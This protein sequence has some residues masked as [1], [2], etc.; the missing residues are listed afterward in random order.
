MVPE[1]TLNNMRVRRLTEMKNIN[2]ELEKLGAPTYDQVAL[3][4]KLVEA[5]HG[6][7]KD[8]VKGASRRKRS[9][10]VGSTSSSKRRRKSGEKYRDSALPRDVVIKS[11]PSPHHHAIGPSIAQGA[12][13]NSYS[14]AMGPGMNVDNQAAPAGF[15]AGFGAMENLYNNAMSPEMSINTS[16]GM[17]TAP[18]AGTAINAG[19]QNQF[20]MP[21]GS[22][23]GDGSQTTGTAPSVPV[24]ETTQGVSTG[25]SIG[26]TFAPS[27]MMQ[28]QSLPAQGMQLHDLQ[29]L[30]SQQQSQLQGMLT[31]NTNSQPTG[32]G[33]SNDS[34]YQQLF[35]GLFGQNSTGESSSMPPPPPPPQ[36]QQ[37]QQQSTS[38]GD[39]D[40]TDG[41]NTDSFMQGWGEAFEP[42]PMRPK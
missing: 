31:T 22:L 21:G 29:R 24:Q 27:L 38:N 4:Q 28:A 37:Q 11:T 14:G 34:Q 42:T 19:V 6:A 15:G 33:Q 10:G 16:S 5:E 40:D 7:T 30:L 35:G 3:T 18:T 23:T 36:Q 41:F 26:D 12:A 1:E 9:G 2:N 13:T 25:Q 20:G 8:F 39:G 17:Q 32:Q